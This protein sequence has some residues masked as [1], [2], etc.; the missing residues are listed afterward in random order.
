M[1][2]F[3]AVTAS[4]NTSSSPPS[5]SLVLLFPLP[6]SS[7]SSS[8]PSSSPLP[9]HPLFPL[10]FFLLIFFLPQTEFYVSEVS[11][12]LTT[13]SKLTFHFESPCSH[14]P[15]GRITDVL[16]QSQGFVHAMQILSQLNYIPKW[17]WA[18]KWKASHLA[19]RGHPRISG[20]FPELFR[21][22]LIITN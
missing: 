4:T 17:N 10:P 21:I 12:E 14:L 16:P 22:K 5:S 11:L 6:S 8:S 3:R 1:F 18:S 20:A 13:S 2:R 19:L 9:L 15:S 7:P